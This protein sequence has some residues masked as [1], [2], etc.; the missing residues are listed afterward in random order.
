MH[1]ANGVGLA[2]PQVGVLKRII[3]VDTA[4]SDEDASEP[5]RMANPEIVWVSDD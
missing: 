2:A 3:V 5:Y 4:A 1:A